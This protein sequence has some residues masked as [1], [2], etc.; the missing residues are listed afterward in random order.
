MVCTPAGYIAVGYANQ[1]N[2][3]WNHS[4]VLEMTAADESRDTKGERRQGRITHP[5]D[6]FHQLPSPQSV[7]NPETDASAGICSGQRGVVA[8]SC[9]CWMTVGLAACCE[10]TNADRGQAFIRPAR[11]SPTRSATGQDWSLGGMVCGLLLGLG[12]NDLVFGAEKG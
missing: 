2:C 12:A 5:T 11:P 4:P 8:L 1:K 6:S 3:T 7:W 9:V 10:W